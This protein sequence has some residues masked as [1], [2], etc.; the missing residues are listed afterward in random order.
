MLSTELRPPFLR[1]ESLDPRCWRNVGLFPLC[2]IQIVDLTHNSL[3]SGVVAA[4]ILN[5]GKGFRKELDPRF[6]RWVD[7]N[8]LI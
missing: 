6:E 3:R 8:D 5:G 7:H 1:S 2:R 4:N